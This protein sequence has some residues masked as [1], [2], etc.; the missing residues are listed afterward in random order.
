M[1]GPMVNAGYESIPYPYGIE[2]L[3]GV[4]KPLGVT[5]GILLLLGVLGS[6]ISLVVRFRHSRGEEW[7]DLCHHKQ[8]RERNQ[9]SS[10]CDH[11][12]A[13]GRLRRGA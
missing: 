12:Q 8:P 7:R 5:S 6:A 3:G 13:S 10:T 4:L 11:P 9:A 2:A 1:P